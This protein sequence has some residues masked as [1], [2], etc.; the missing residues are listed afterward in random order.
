[1]QGF[2]FAVLSAASSP[3]KFLAFLKKYKKQASLAKGVFSALFLKNQQLSTGI[4]HAKLYGI[5]N[6]V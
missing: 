3:Q 4:H 1:M 2:F 6:Q 5:I